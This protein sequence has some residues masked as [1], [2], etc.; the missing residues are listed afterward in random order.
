MQHQGALT[1]ELS[2]LPRYVVK[3]Y[4]G[5]SLG[6]QPMPNEYP[7]FL[8]PGNSGGALPLEGW[9][10]LCPWRGQHYR[11]G[12]LHGLAFCLWFGSSA[13]YFPVAGGSGR[14]CQWVIPSVI[15]PELW[16]QLPLWRYKIYSPLDCWYAST[17]PV[18]S[19]ISSSTLIHLLMV[20]RLY[21]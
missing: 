13:C 4:R 18:S 20:D 14:G 16:Y 8:V 3:I 1:P 7:G 10:V 21:L 11:V 17:S 6:D 5:R 12:R 19:G 15:I 9:L 2:P